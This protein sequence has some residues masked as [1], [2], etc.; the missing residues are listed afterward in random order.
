MI[1][2]DTAF[3]YCYPEDYDKITREIGVREEWANQKLEKFGKELRKT[4]RELKVSGDIEYRIKRKFSIYK[5]LKKQNIDIEKVYDLLALRVITKTV[6]DCYVII[7]E[8]HQ[9]YTPLPGQVER[10]HR[11]SAK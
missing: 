6:A 9:K 8:I 7:G 4:L 3:K 11:K 2:E 5:K 1:L 10:F